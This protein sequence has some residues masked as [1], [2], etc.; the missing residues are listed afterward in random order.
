VKPRAPTLKTVTFNV[1]GGLSTHK[2]ASG[3]VTP[4]R[5][6]SSKPASNPDTAP[7]P[8]HLSRTP[9]IPFPPPLASEKV[10]LPIFPPNKNFPFPTTKLSMN[11]PRPNNSVVCRTTRRTLPA[12]LKSP[13]ARIKPGNVSAS[14]WTR[15]PKAGRPN[16]CLHHYRRRTLAGLRSQRRCVSDNGAGRASWPRQQRRR[17]LRLRPKGYYLRLAA[18]GSCALVTISGKTGKVELGDKEHQARLRAAGNSGEKGENQMAAGTAA[19]VA[20]NQWHNVKLQFLRRHYHRL[21]GWCAG[22]GHDQQSLFAGHGRPHYRRP[23]DQK[24]RLFRQPAHQRVGAATPR[25]TVFTKNQSPIY[26]P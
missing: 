11:T 19:N 26:K 10:H 6:S 18:D 9:S 4:P 13:I 22:F 15:N 14:S 7:S 16:G 23:P 12:F 5:N 20:G 1:S 2:L 21:R 8:S 24:H 17:W 25:P 3:A